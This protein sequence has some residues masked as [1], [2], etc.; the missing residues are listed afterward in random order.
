MSLERLR[1]VMVDSLPVKPGTESSL[2]KPFPCCTGYETI[3][4]IDVLAMMLMSA[5]GRKDC[6]VMTHGVGAL[7]ER[8]RLLD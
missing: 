6:V 1:S 5:G 8:H 2:A 4:I 7:A 3:L